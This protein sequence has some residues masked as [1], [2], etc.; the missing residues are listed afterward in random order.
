MM[1]FLLHIFC[2]VQPY[3]PS[4]TPLGLRRLREMEL[5]ELR[6]DGK[7]ERKMTD[8]IYDYDI[9]NDLGNPDKGKELVRP[10]I[11]GNKALPYP[12]RLRTGRPSAET[13]KVIKPSLNKLL[14]FQSS[15]DN[16]SNSKSFL[17]TKCEGFV[18]IFLY[19]IIIII[20]LLIVRMIKV[21]FKIYEW[22]R[23]NGSG[24]EQTHHCQWRL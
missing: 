3:L 13:G 22:Q 18:Q 9:Y 8:R 16:T 23:V 11:G 5:M 14:F 21:K 4:E 2:Q 1:T 10:S 15:L 6:G 19:I 7:G 12:R 17:C 24:A 20:I